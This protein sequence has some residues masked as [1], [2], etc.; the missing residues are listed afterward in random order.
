MPSTVISQS[1]PSP[2][3]IGGTS[4]IQQI[5]E[6]RARVTKWAGDVIKDVADYVGQFEGVVRPYEF[7]NIIFEEA[8]GQELSAKDDLYE[9]ATKIKN[10]T[11][12]VIDAMLES[13]GSQISNP[14]DIDIGAIVDRLLEYLD[15]EIGSGN[16]SILSFR[17]LVRAYVETVLLDSAFAVLSTE[18]TEIN[19]AVEAFKS[20]AKSQLDEEMFMLERRTINEL[21]TIGMLDSSVAADLL[22][23][24]SARKARRYIEIDEKA[25]QLR[26]EY[27]R[28]AWNRSIERVRVRIQALGLL[29][30]SLPSQL[31]TVL[32]DLVASRIL[33]P[34]SFVTNFPN[35]LATG[36][37]AL[38]NLAEML[39]RNRLQKPMTQGS[40]V[41]IYGN[42][43]DAIARNLGAL[44]ESVAKLA[45]WEAS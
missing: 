10:R 2:P 17:A 45:T 18:L 32:G 13:L 35:I 7:P 29:P 37:G 24:I 19:T 16:D 20:S 23:R 22:S 8:S 34:R 1:A 21:E 4:A 31:Y 26:F 25:E 42:F 43:V 27:L 9:L 30:L 5:M 6:Y 44:G 38:T 36:V 40:I 41:Q 11:D 3:S 28:D 15:I 14:P 12:Q 33:D 39:Q